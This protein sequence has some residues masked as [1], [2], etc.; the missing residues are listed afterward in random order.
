MMRSN[1]HDRL[2]A[3]STHAGGGIVGRQKKM[4][5]DTQFIIS[6]NEDGLRLDAVVVAHFP[7]T[8][9]LLAQRAIA[10]GDVTV[11]GKA[12]HK[13]AKVCA[14][15]SVCVKKLPESNDL[16]VLPDATMALEI[17]FEDADLVAA[18]KPAGM[19][20]HPLRPEEQGTLANGLVARWP[21]LAEVGDQPLMA[22]V[23]HRIDGD[24]S[25][26]VL[27]ARNQAAFQGIR[28]QFAAHTVRKEYVALVAGA[29][30]KDTGKLENEL[31]HQP[32]RR[33]RMVDARRLKNPERPMRAVTEF[34]VAR[35]VGKFTLLDVTIFTG[36]THQIRCQL[37]L[38]GHAIVG[39]TLYGGVVVKNFPR[40]FLHASAVELRQ[41][42]TGDALR[43]EAPLTP[44]LREFLGK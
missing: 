17:L 22:G 40:H 6:T 8:T 19:D 21:E 1:W 31:V 42:R 10:A 27:A 20:V 12:S 16:R 14:G 39:D 3:L 30:E 7:A 2:N 24:T 15:M 18:N 25:G 4:I 35:K 26:L 36:V 32:W 5:S 9:R 41:P 11:D 13:G 37:A 44:D 38:A 23:V 43:I 33:G 29:M 34:K 28:A